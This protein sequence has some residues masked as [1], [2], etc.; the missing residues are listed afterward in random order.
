[1][2]KETFQEKI[3]LARTRKGYTQSEVSAETGISQSIIAYLESGKREPSLENLGKLIDFYEVSAD[4]VL[5]T[6]VNK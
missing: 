5:G 1:M 4:W 3:R 2:Y 6:G